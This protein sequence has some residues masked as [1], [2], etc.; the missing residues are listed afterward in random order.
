MENRP[1]RWEDR[2]ATLQGKHWY[3]ASTRQSSVLGIF[4]I[5]GHLGASPESRSSTGPVQRAVLLWDCSSLAGVKPSR[6][7]GT[8]GFPA[9][10]T[11]QTLTA[12]E[13]DLRSNLD[14]DGKAKQIPNVFCFPHYHCAKSCLVQH[15]KLDLLK[16][17]KKKKRLS[18]KS[19][20]S[21]TTESSHFRAKADFCKQKWNDLVSGNLKFLWSPE[22]CG[23]LF[24]WVISRALGIRTDSGNLLLRQKC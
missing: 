2:S 6:N 11:E 8:P 22:T 10:S 16:T 3:K 7:F 5:P 20:F 9:E 21:S 4:P 24:T 14:W 1:C 19:G 18:S 13:K 17:A 12:I 23:W 15:E